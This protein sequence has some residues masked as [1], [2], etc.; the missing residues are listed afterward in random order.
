MTGSAGL[1]AGTM[2]D[3]CGALGLEAL[4]E[5]ELEFAGQASTCDRWRL[6]P[7]SGGSRPQTESR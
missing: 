2:R 7:P 1:D 4:G 6:E 3:L 5:V